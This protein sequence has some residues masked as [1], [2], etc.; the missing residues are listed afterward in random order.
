M[1]KSFSGLHHKALQSFVHCHLCDM[2]CDFFRWHTPAVAQNFG[3]RT[4]T[5]SVAEAGSDVLS[6][7]SDVQ[8]RVAAGQSTAITAATNAVTVMKDLKI[9]DR[10]K[11]GQAVASQD[12]SDLKHRLALLEA[13]FEEAEL[14]LADGQSR[15][16]LMTGL[17]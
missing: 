9:G 4:A 5:V 16:W 1:L 11:A 13:Q 8:G 14:R 12:A 17:F 7:L 15:V 2:C 3:G 10:I 6:L